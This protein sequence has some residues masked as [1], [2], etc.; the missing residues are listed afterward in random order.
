MQLTLSQLLAILPLEEVKR[1][2][3]ENPFKYS[4]H[5]VATQISKKFAQSLISLD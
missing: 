3:I 5:Q 4:I 1:F 2:G